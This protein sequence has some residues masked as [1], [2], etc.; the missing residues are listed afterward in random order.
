M[1]LFVF[2]VFQ[3]S[4]A[5]KRY[6]ITTLLEGAPT[7]RRQVEG[8]FTY[9]AVLTLVIVGT[10]VQYVCCWSFEVFAC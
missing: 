2:G 3:P 9:C 10:H 1:R 4:H 5:V 8:T 7:L 6:Q